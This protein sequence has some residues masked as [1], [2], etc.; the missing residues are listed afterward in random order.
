TRKLLA[1]IPTNGNDG[2]MLMPSPAEALMSR[3][4]LSSAALAAFLLAAPFAPSAAP[5]NSSLALRARTILQAHCAGCHGGPDKARGGF[6][7]VLDRDRLVEA[8]QVV[9]GK[10][11]ESPLYQRILNGEMPPPSKRVRPTPSEQMALRQ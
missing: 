10:P 7:H 4:F 6:G 1:S 5:P 2:R 9:L 8:G 3:T 11:G